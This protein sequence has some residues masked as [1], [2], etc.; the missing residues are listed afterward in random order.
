VTAAGHLFSTLQQLYPELPAPRIWSMIGV[1]E[2]IGI[3]DFGPPEILTT[4]DA[5]AVEQW[6]TRQHLAELS[7]WALQRDN[8]GCPGTNGS[9]TC[10]G[11]AQRPWQFSHILN[12]FTS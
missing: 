1:T 9:N 4:A 5:P 12:R 8:G 6:A 7:F 11:V 3:D 10:S 2:M